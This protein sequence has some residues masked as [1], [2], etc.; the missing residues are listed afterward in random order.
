MIAQ[1][2]G[3]QHLVTWPALRAAQVDA[4]GDGAHAARVDVHAVAVAAVH[5]LRVA[6]DQAHA[7]LLRTLGH[8]G[9]DA[10]EVLDGEALLQHE[11]AAE[12]AR[13]GAA[14]GHIVHRAADGEAADVAAGEE[15]GRHHE[16][17]GRERQPLARHGGGQHRRIVAAQ[18]LVAGVGGEEHVVDDAL[19]H[20]AAAAVS[21]HDRGIHTTPCPPMS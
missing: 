18:Q 10:L 3:D 2:A 9:A 6:G 20:R 17:V 14:R 16:A 7:G 15:V 5:H 8:G 13:G 11:A 19:H 4:L 21:Q 1:R 12:V